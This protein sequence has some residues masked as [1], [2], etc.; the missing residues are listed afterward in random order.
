MSFSLDF[1][2]IA[3]VEDKEPMTRNE[4]RE[5]LMQILY[6]M[7]ATGSMDHETAVRLSE[8]RL[9]GNNRDRGRMILTGIVDSIGE[10]DDRINEHSRSWKTSR[11]PKVDLAIMRLALGELMFDDKLPP[12][13]AINEAVDLAKKFSMEK[14]PRFI[15]GVLGSIIKSDGQ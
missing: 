9:S 2:I 5:I 15:N 4:A 7:D 3:Y 13:V 10:I 12:A 8:E 6:E 1:G 14:S 11:M